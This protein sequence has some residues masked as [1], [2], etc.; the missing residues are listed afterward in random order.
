[1]RH[2][3]SSDRTPALHAW[4]RS[5]FTHI[6]IALALEAMVLAG[7]W[8]YAQTG[9]YGLSVVLRRGMTVW[10]TVAPDD[11]RLSVPMRL[12]LSPT[13][14]AAHAGSFAWHLPA[15][16]LEAAEMP[17]VA[18][19]IEVDRLLLARL[20]PRRFRFEVLS[21]PAGHLDIDDWLSRAGAA[22]VV[23]GSYYGPDGQ[24][25]TP[26]LSNGRGLGPGVYDARHGAFVATGEGASVVDLAGR[27][28]QPAF[29]GALQAMVSFPMLIGDDGASRAGRSDP[30][31]LANRSFVAEDA[32][33][34]I[35]IGTTREAFFSLDRLADF[36]RASPLGLVR[37]LNLDGGPPACQAI[38]AGNYR[39]SF[40]GQWETQTRNGEIR[41]LGH[42]IGNRRWG[43][44]LVLVARPKAR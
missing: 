2:S 34:R 29:A 41:L 32:Q 13:V 20:D 9:L 27:G 21:E 26:V 28:W 19:G 31:W 10:T 5:T 16:G 23:N 35:V 43:L 33:G 17:V 15:P 22:L 42:L 24:P 18:A 3:S 39:R 12:A 4:Q 40:C 14:P 25:A 1:M 8:L 7:A 11:R 36:L 30:R 44:P 6:L 37:A 38:A